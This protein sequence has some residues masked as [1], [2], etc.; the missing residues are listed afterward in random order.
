MPDSTHIRG[1]SASFR[2]RFA[3][4]AFGE[5]QVCAQCGQPLV[6]S[7]AWRHSV[8]LLQLL[9]LAADTSFYYLCYQDIGTRSFG[10]CLAV[11]A[12]LQLG[13]WLFAPVRHLTGAAAA[14]RNRQ[15]MTVA[16]VLLVLSLGYLAWSRYGML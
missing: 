7:R 9:A 15:R 14:R 16:A 8:L 10:L 1:C 3:L 5:P 13:L 6:F 2:Q 4:A 12:A 11:I